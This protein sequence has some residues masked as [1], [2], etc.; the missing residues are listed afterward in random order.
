MTTDSGRRGQVT[1]LTDRRSERGALDRLVEAVRAGESRALVMRGDPG[2]GKTAH[3]AGDTYLEVRLPLACPAMRSTCQASHSASTASG[4]EAKPP[5]SS[6]SKVVGAFVGGH[7]RAVQAR[8]I[9]PRASR[10][11]RYIQ[12][13]HVV[14]VGMGLRVVRGLQVDQRAGRVV[15]GRFDYPPAADEVTRGI[16]PPTPAA[17]TTKA[18]PKP[19]RTAAPTT[20][21]PAPTTAAPTKSK[22]PAPPPPPPTTA[23]AAAP[24]TPSGCHP[25]TNGGNCYE[26]GEY[27]RNSDH[28]VSGVAGDGER[29][30][31]EDNNGWRW[32]PAEA[33]R[34]LASDPKPAL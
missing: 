33:A 23:P 34:L 15:V 14:I 13:R 1:G 24:T 28:G 9:D 30:I 5:R 2:A 8:R 31:C 17:V 10:V 26:P 7:V 22:A 25:L 6:A 21:A 18:K 4:R 12:R 3:G 32:E 16:S 11:D 27:C 29:I 19:R 20:A